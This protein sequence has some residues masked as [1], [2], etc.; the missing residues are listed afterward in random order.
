MDDFQYIFIARH[1]GGLNAK[2][3]HHISRKLLVRV[4][5]ERL[6]THY[7]SERT[8][9]FISMNRLSLP[10]AFYAGWGYIHSKS[11]CDKPRTLCHE[12]IHACALSVTQ[13]PRQLGSNQYFVAVRVAVKLFGIRAR[14]QHYCAPKRISAR[15]KS[16]CARAPVTLE[17]VISS[18]VLTRWHHMSFGKRGIWLMTYLLILCTRWMCLD[19]A[20]QS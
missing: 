8:A 17:K 11:P 13:C 3:S 14:A 10:M 20:K 1:V 18:S 7:Q 2:S 9:Y 5:L 4:K 12:W 15:G 6:I 19:G 16:G